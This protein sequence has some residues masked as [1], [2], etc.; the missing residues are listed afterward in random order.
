MTNGIIIQEV[1]EPILRRVGIRTVRTVSG[2]T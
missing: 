2:I 1:Q